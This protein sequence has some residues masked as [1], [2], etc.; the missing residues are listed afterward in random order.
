MCNSRLPVC[1]RTAVM[2]L[3]TDYWCS[4][5]VA[6][7]MIQLSW[8]LEQL[9]LTW[10][11]V[12][13]KVSHPAW[14][15]KRDEVSVVLDDQD[16]VAEPF[17]QSGFFVKVSWKLD[18]EVESDSSELIFY[19]NIVSV[20]SRMHSVLC[21]ILCAN[22]NSTGMTLFIRFLFQIPYLFAKGICRARGKAGLELML[23]TP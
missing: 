12:V 16:K 21:P 11:I 6:A 3:S 7:R 15:W 1:S 4:K 8:I 5:T 9:F 19:F 22:I 23:W 13:W 18:M 20:L 10:G 2:E 17:L 14:C